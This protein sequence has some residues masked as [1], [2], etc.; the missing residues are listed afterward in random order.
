MTVE[1]TARLA[2]VSTRGSRGVTGL[3]RIAGATSRD[4]GQAVTLTLERTSAT[5]A[6]LA[7]GVS[8]WDNGR[9]ALKM[10]RSGRQV[11]ITGTIGF[12]PMF[13]T[14]ELRIEQQ[15]FDRS[16][17]TGQLC[18][19]DLN[20]TIARAAGLTTIVGK[21]GAY[22]QSSIGSVNLSVRDHGDIRLIEGSTSRQSEGRV[23]LEQVRD[24]DTWKT[25]GRL[26]GWDVTELSHPATMRDLEL[27]DTTLLIVLTQAVRR[28][29]QKI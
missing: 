28:W 13:R 7:G 3:A 16:I 18:G 6:I 10:T 26:G 27:F 17:V 4:P 19:R 8:K 14:V 23:K 2:L 15:T 20:L 9:T 25:T 12:E 29:I 22:E 21:L 11:T 5:E 24:G 1:S